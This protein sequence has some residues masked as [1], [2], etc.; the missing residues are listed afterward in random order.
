MAGLCAL[1][2]EGGSIARMAAGRIVEKVLMT[3]EGRR[4]AERSGPASASYGI[5]INAGLAGGL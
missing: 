4:G 5:P 1:A 2:D 3:K